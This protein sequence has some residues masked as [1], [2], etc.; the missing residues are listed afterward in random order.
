MRHVLRARVGRHDQDDVAEID[1]L[2]R[3]IGQLAVVHH[4]QQDVEEVGMGLLDLVEQQHAM[5]MLVDRV[6]QQAALVEADIARRRADQPRNR[7]ALHIFGHVEARQLEPEAGGELARRLGLADAGR[8]GEEIA[9]DR[10]LRIAQARAGELDRRRQRGDRLVL[11]V[12]DAL[13][14]VLE[15]LQ[16]LGVVLGDGLGGNARHRGDRRLDLLDADRLLALGLGDQHLRGAGLVD[17]VDRLVGQLAVVDVARRKLHRR[18]HR[19]V[20]CSGSCGTPRNRA[21]GP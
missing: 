5:R 8:A 14:G 4:L 11:A 10:L 7:V 12:D 18:L 2:A 19:L 21:S 1:L 15:M 20:R 9:A 3:M 6:G 17:H 16:H 13:E